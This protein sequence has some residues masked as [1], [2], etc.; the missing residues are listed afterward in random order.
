MNKSIELFNEFKRTGKQADYLK[1]PKYD[2]AQ[3][4]TDQTIPLPHDGIE[5]ACKHGVVVGCRRSVNS[6]NR[7]PNDLK[8]GDS[9]ANT[10]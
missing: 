10:D 1:W 9:H 8:G 4:S 6:V 5:P 3:S 2:A 7:A